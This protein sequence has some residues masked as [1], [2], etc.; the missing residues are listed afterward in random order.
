MKV[1]DIKSHDY[2][3]KLVSLKLKLSRN[4]K[5]DW[6]VLHRR[7][8]HVLTDYDKLAQP[9]RETE[10]KER[11]ESMLMNFNT[12]TIKSAKDW[13]QRPEREMN[14]VEVEKYKP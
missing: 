4:Y 13:E 1:V 9:Y 7:F 2:D 8:F 6:K 5:H 3:R 11:N 12:G 14:L 10:I